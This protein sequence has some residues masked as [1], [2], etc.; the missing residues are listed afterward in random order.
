MDSPITSPVPLT[1]LVEYQPGSVVSRVI[2]RNEGGSQTLFAFAEGEGLGEHTN[3]NDAVILVLEGSAEVT[4]GGVVHVVGTGE[5][6]CLPASVPHALVGGPP[7]KMLLTLL[8][9]HGGA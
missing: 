1:D 8:K 4:V 9:T 7:F 2:F 5:A 6:L 3:P